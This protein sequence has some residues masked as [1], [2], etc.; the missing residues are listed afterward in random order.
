MKIDEIYQAKDELSE[1]LLDTFA[2]EV[3]APKGINVKIA[4]GRYTTN[5]VQLTFGFFYGEPRNQLEADIVLKG[6]AYCPVYELHLTGIQNL[7]AEITVKRIRSR[8]EYKRN[9]DLSD[10]Y[11]RSQFVS[12]LLGKLV[13][14]ASDIKDENEAA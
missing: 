13:M 10:C 2:E 3:F 9:V 7:T 14:L 11:Y 8:Y 4:G 1:K 5:V 6:V 12:A